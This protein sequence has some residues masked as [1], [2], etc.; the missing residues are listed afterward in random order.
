MLRFCVCLNILV[1]PLLFGMLTFFFYIT[2]LK[3]KMME[4]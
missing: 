2:S 1:F 3:K 4:D